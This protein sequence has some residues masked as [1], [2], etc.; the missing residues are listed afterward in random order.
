MNGYLMVAIVLSC[1][2]TIITIALVIGTIQ[3]ECKRYG[4]L[5]SWN[6]YQSANSAY[7]D[8]LRYNHIPVFKFEF[9]DITHKPPYNSSGVIK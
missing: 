7:E 5:V 6:S 4:E 2:I 9:P 3:Y 1:I 8:C